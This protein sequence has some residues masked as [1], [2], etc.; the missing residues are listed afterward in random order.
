MIKSLKGN[1]SALKL[2]DKKMHNTF[3]PVKWNPDCFNY[4][5]LEYKIKESNDEKM[6]LSIANRST[7]AN[8]IKN[9]NETAYSKFKANAYLHWYY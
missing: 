6:M 4:E 3:N 9:V 7:I 8:V 2:V 1:E 5:F